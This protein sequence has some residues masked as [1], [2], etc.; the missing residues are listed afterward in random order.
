MPQGYARVL[1]ECAVGERGCRAGRSCLE[2]NINGPPV[3][4]T[5]QAG[6]RSVRVRSCDC[7]VPTCRMIY[8]NR[9][10]TKT[11]IHHEHNLG[12]S[13]R[14]RTYTPLCVQITITPRKTAD[15]HHCNFSTFIH[16]TIRANHKSIHTIDHRPLTPRVASA[17]QSYLMP[18][19]VCAYNYDST[20][21]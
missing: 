13:F 18:H 7:L 6:T 19:T 3:S 11:P 4:A 20:F 9:N 8:T 5:R 21:P 14:R 12:L 1:G 15:N 16:V 10:Y 2:G 17:T